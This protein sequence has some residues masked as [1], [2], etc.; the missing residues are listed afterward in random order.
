MKKNALCIMAICLSLA[1]NP[2]QSRATTIAATSS[3]VFSD[4]AAAGK[5]LGRLNEINDMDKTNLTFSEKKALR[6]EVVALRSGLKDIG[7]GVY[8]SVGAIIIILLLL[9]LLT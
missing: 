4:S 2:L 8:L 5:L 3:V 9:I 1:F 6:K 7:K